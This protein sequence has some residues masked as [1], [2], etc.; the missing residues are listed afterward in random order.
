MAEPNLKSIPVKEFDVK[1]IVN[2]IVNEKM[3]SLDE[4]TAAILKIQD[5]EIESLN[6]RLGMFEDML[7]NLLV[8]NTSSEEKLK[9]IKYASEVIK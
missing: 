3:K 4:N 1:E 8:K 5:E 2:G 9:L 7:L 6:E